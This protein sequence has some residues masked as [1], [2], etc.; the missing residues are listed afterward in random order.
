M[1]TDLTPQSLEIRGTAATHEHEL[2]GSAIEQ[3]EDDEAL[4]EGVGR[5]ADRGPVGC[6]GLARRVAQVL[7]IEVVREPRQR[8]G[9]RGVGGRDGAVVAL[10]MTDDEPLVVPC[11]RVEATPIGRKIAEDQVRESQRLAKIPLR[12][13]R[14]VEVDE[15][16]AEK[17]VVLEVR[18]EMRPASAPGAQQPPVGSQQRPQREV[19]RALRSPGGSAAP[20]G[21]EPPP[22][23]RR[24]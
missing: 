2:D 6:D 4:R 22:P 21:R 9:G 7:P 17:G 18:C 5:A 14:L 1:R 3:V 24:S 13:S 16:L 11:R 10:A 20:R 8:V 19:G 15:R 12:R 23:S